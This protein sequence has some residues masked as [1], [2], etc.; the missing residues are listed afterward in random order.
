MTVGQLAHGAQIGHRHGLSAGCVVGYGHDDER[1]AALVV[2]HGL[3]QLVDVNVAL[4]GMLQLCVA[5]LVDGAVHGERL[6]ALDMPLGGVEMRVARHHVAGLDQC[7]EHHVL[8]GAAL[9]RRD[10]HR[11]SGDALYGVLHPEE[12]AGAGITLVA[13]HHGAPLTVAH[14][15]GAGVGQK[16]DI[17]LFGRKLKYIVM[18]CLDPFFALFTRTGTDGF[19]HLDAPRFGK[20]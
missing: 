10:N 14:G 4:E 9:M 18:R 17:H 15:S 20:R 13:H 2:G 19:H 11:E 3:L 8:G 5:G 6:A 12:G 7:A 16:V 1:H